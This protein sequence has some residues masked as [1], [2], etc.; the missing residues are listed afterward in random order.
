MDCYIVRVYR[1]FSRTD[2][3]EGEIAGL[4][5][6][7]GEENSGKPFTSY[8]GLVSAMKDEFSVSAGSSHDVEKAGVDTCEV[9]T[10]R[11]RST[12]Q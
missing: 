11:R 10:L 7:V 4:L 6:R 8:K 1:H 3:E 12:R 2:G 9:H 5:E